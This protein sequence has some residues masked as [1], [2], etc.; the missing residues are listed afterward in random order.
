MK[1][2]SIGRAKHKEIPCARQGFD[3]L[4]PNNAFGNIAVPKHLIIGNDEK[5]IF[6]LI[7]FH[8][9]VFT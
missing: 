7:G 6:N 3:L 9:P 2:G 4:A 5:R 1:P 8:W